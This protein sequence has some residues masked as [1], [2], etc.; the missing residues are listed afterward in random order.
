LPILPKQQMLNGMKTI[1]SINYL[2]EF[3]GKQTNLEEYK[4]IMGGRQKTQRYGTLMSPRES[5]KQTSTFDRKDIVSRS[6][7]RSP[8]KPSSSIKYAVCV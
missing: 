4:Q 5:T 1:E 7:I 6:S 2:E 3:D 8:K